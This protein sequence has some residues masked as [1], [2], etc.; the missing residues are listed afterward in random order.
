MVA[1]CL[2]GVVLAS[3]RRQASSSALSS[4]SGGWLAAR[5]YLEERGARVELSARPL[6]TSAESEDEGPPPIWVLAFPWQAPLSD[7]EL[8]ALGAHLRAGGTVVAAYSELASGLERDVLESLGLEIR[9]VRGP[10]PL[11]P[12]KWWTFRREVWDLAAAGGWSD[13]ETAPDLVVP[14][15]DHVPVAPEGAAVLYRRPSP[16]D[17]G[18]DVPVVFRYRL[19]RGEVLALPAAV[20]SNAYLLGAGHADFLESLRL[21]LAGDWR[22]DEYHH[23]LVDAGLAG[24]NPSTFAWDLFLLHLACFYALGLLALVRRFGPAWREAGVAAG[25]TSAFLRNLGALHRRLRHHQAAARLLAVRS[26]ELDPSLPELDLP[27]VSSDAELVAFA[28][29]LTFL[30]RRPAA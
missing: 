9:T 10:A 5:R 30:S 13:P 14:A 8:E 28:R 6:G 18:E 25:S 23:G 12:W 22:F 3:P 24:E 26:R 17:A 7:G 27:D 29:R 19:H 15:M 21:G 11:A 4:G 20:L 1:L 16:E 2:F